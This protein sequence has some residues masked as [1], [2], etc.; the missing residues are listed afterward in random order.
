ME[1]DSLSR[2]L[3][4]ILHADV[5]GS[6][7]LVRINET[8]AHE[9]IQNTFQRFSTTID[10][11]VGITHELRGDALVAEFKRASDAVAA[12]LTFQAENTQ[13][14]AKLEDEIQPQLRIGISMGEVVIADNTITGAGVVLAQ[15]LEQLAEPGGVC[16]QGAAYETVPQRL[17]FEYESLGEQQVKGFEEPVRAYAVSLKSGESI[18]PPE[19]L[20]M[21]GAAQRERQKQRWIVAG[22]M[23]LVVIVGGGLAWFQPWV[24]REAPASIERMTFP[25]PDKPS[26]VV[27]PFDNLSGDPSLD[28]F[29]D[30]IT[31][32][33]ITELSRHPYLTVASRNSSFTYK[34]KPTKAREISE[35]LGVRYLLEGS[36]RKKD[37]EVRIT[38]QL[39]DATADTHM[40]AERFD[41]QGTDIFALQDRVA[42]R[43]A[44]TVAGH[45]GQVREAEW[46]RVGTMDAAGLEEYDYY[47]RG[48]AI[49]YEFTPEAMLKAREIWH[50][51]LRKFP[52]SGLL[53]IK[54]GWTY[55]QF[56]EN[57]WSQTPEEDIK[58]AYEL[59]QEG[60]TDENLSVTGRWVG[61]WL[62]AIVHLFHK[63]DYDRALEE[64]AAANELAPSD[65]EVLV[66]LSRVPAYAGKPELSLEWA[67]RAINREVRVP[68]YYYEGL[69][70]GHYANGDCEQALQAYENV[71]W[72]DLHVSPPRVACFVELGRL[73][74]ARSEMSRLLEENTYLTEA[75][76]RLRFPYKSPAFFDRYLSALKA[77]GLP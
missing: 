5:V 9:R 29:S 77:A 58:K 64:A 34:G 24:P 41:E 52:E 27:L 62:N 8:L 54:I 32:D 68:D 22:G 45:S 69:G 13:F 38:A 40:W 21:S 60:L 71:P 16:I 47:L 36:V 23:A 51:G 37:D 49:F 46:Q 70:L 6:T 31:E 48:H 4:V 44:G 42:Q 35:A 66:H 11:Y 56:F 59:A 75:T 30:G 43:I 3:A 74:E 2:K 20:A 55:E 39:I 19:V 14:N 18:P 12:A 53:R 61:H 7:G 63:R 1:E 65:G 50:E 57:G 25:L 26:I 73:E 28:Y 10:S 33:L 15:R 76:V 17:P 72:S 67:M